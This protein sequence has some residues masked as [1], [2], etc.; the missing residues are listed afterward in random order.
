M[1]T[2]LICNGHSVTGRSGQGGREGGGVGLGGASPCA[3]AQC[4]KGSDRIEM[5]CEGKSAVFVPLKYSWV[6]GASAKCV[7]AFQCTMK[8]L[9]PRYGKYFTPRVPDMLNR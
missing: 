9:R 4:V 7:E 8:V 5:M 6:K 1:A 2:A 3:V